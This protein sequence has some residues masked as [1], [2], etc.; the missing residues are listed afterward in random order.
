MKAVATWVVMALGIVVFFAALLALVVG[1]IS[2]VTHIAI[3]GIALVGVTQAVFITGSLFVAFVGALVYV[4]GD[5][6]SFNVAE[7]GTF[8]E[9]FPR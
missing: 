8:R 9:S 4:L 6:L 3:R 7:Y 5:R 2:L 1:L